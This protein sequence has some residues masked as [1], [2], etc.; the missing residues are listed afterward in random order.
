MLN[1]EGMRCS[2]VYRESENF[3]FNGWLQMLHVQPMMYLIYNSYKIR[4]NDTTVS[5]RNLTV[6][7][8][9]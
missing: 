9:Y 1:L 7:I 8:Y 3:I 5:W 2:V 6:A 4:N